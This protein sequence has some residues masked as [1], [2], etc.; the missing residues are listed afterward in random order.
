MRIFFFSAVFN[1]ISISVV[2][3]TAAAGREEFTAV[4][5]KSGDEPNDVSGLGR[6]NVFKLSL[7]ACVSSAA[8]GVRFPRRDGS[9]SLFLARPPDR[10]ALRRVISVLQCRL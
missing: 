8:A 7:S 5:V 3:V 4:A 6:C 1:V 9:L 2:T 10:L